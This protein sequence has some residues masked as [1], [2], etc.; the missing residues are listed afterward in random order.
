[1]PFVAMVQYYYIAYVGN[2]R[3]VQEMLGN[4]NINAANEDLITALHV[5]AV[6]GSCNK[7]FPSRKRIDSKQLHVTNFRQ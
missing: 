3:K 1:M 4:S 6:E 7:Q 5:A 2:V